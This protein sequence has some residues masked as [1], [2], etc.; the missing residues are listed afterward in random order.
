MKI[1]MDVDYWQEYY[2]LKRLIESGK[3]VP[4]DYTACKV[5]YNK[6]KIKSEIVNT[7]FRMLTEQ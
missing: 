1:D 6:A 7:N 3:G 5:T 2:R 4:A